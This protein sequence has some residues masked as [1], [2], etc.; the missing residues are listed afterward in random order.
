MRLQRAAKIRQRG[1]AIIFKFYAIKISLFRVSTLD[2]YKGLLLRMLRNK[3]VHFL[4]F[5]RKTIK[6]DLHS[7]IFYDINSLLFRISM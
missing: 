2:D 4:E 6:K 3:K 7:R 5:L 1:V